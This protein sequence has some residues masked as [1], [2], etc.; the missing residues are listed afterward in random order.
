[1][2]VTCKQHASWELKILYDGTVSLMEGD[3]GKASYRMEAAGSRVVLPSSSLFTV[4]DTQEQGDDS[5]TKD[6]L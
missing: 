1:M 4:T 3:L 6:E 5:P 2:E